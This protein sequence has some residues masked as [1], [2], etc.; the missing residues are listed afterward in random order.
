M[1]IRAAVENDLDDLL[2]M[3]LALAESEGLVQGSLVTKAYLKRCL[4]T[5]AR[6][7][8]CFVLCDESGTTKALSGMLMVQMMMDTALGANVLHIKDFFIK[9]AYRDQGWG[10]KLFDFASAYARR[11]G[12]AAMILGVHDENVQALEF[13]DSL[14]GE[15][16]KGLGFYKWVLDTGA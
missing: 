9:E 4:F 11:E 2:E 8:K 7:A 15:R 14:G 16:I 5:Q 1:K 10:R 12:C 6:I 3:C 13:Y